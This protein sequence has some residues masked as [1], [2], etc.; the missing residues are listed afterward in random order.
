MCTWTWLKETGR[1]LKKSGKE[2]DCFY[3]QPMLGHCHNNPI[4]LLHLGSPCL[5]FYVNLT[6]ISSPS[7][8]NIYFC[9]CCITE[10]P[11][12]WQMAHTC[13]RLLLDC[14]FFFFL[15]WFFVP[16]QRPARIQRRS[17]QIFG[18]IWTMK[19]TAF[20]VITDWNLCGPWLWEHSWGWSSCKASSN[21]DPKDSPFKTFICPQEVTVRT[22]GAIKT[23]ISTITKWDKDDHHRE[24][25]G[26]I[27]PD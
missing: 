11:A 2:C 27:K 24:M 17:R 21:P 25:S 5:S 19:F 16:V 4:N 23:T 10:P 6:W 18:F 9:S 14:F 7:M 22:T 20:R 1:T 13:T 3:L 12:H 8:S 15:F 26:A